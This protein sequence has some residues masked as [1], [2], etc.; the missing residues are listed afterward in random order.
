MGFDYDRVIKYEQQNS[1]LTECPG[2]RNMILDWR[3][4]KVKTQDQVKEFCDVLKKA[5]QARLA[6]D[7]EKGLSLLI[8][9]PVPYPPLYLFVMHTI[10]C[11]NKTCCCPECQL[12]DDVLFAVKLAF[13]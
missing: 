12:N 5:K 7:L 6:E 10:F 13:L 11:E 8:P 3:K 2:T 1:G 4:E 9:A